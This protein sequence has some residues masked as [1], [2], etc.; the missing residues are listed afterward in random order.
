M[1]VYSNPQGTT[2]KLQRIKQTHLSVNDGVCG[3]KHVGDVGEPPVGAVASLSCL[4]VMEEGPSTTDE[5]IIAKFDRGV[6][7]GQTECEISV[8][9]YKL[10]H[11]HAA[12]AQKHRRRSTERAEGQNGA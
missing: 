6:D 8:D 10:Q 3:I 12:K 1:I 7:N 11:R 4:R 5:R 9:G 2:G